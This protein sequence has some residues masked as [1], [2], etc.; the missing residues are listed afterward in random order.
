MDP[1]MYVLVNLALQMRKKA[2]RAEDMMVVEYQDGTSEEQKEEQDRFTETM[3]RD[4]SRYTKMA[5]ELGMAV[6]NQ[7]LVVNYHAILARAQASAAPPS[8]P[9]DGIVSELQGI[10]REMAR[11]SKGVSCHLSKFQ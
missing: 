1:S 11:F 2:P 4:C 7:A 3:A 9:F 10:Q 5:T 6:Q 8:Q